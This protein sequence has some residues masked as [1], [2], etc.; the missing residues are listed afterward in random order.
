M[1]KKLIFILGDQL[2]RSL[3]TSE[4]VNKQDDVI[5]MCEV[6]EEATYVKHHKKKLVFVLSSMRHFAQELRDDGYHVDYVKLNDKH[7]S[8]DFT[9]ELKRAVKRHDVE[10]IVCTFPGEYRVYEMMQS[11]QQETGI[12]VDIRQDT[13]FFSQPDDFK[14]WAD[15]R[16]NLRMEYFYR[17]MRKKHHILMEGDA[18]EGGEWNY[19]KENRQPPKKG[20]QPPDPFSADPD[21]ITKD[22]IE[23]V[24]E[25]FSDHF[26]DIEPFYP[27]VNR[28]QALQALDLFIDERLVDF[29]TYQD[30]MIDDEPWMFHAHISPYLNNGLLLANECVERAQQ[31]YRD[32]DAPLHAVEG[33]IRQILGWREYVRGLY[34]LKMPGYADENALNAT[35][36]LPKFFWDG[37]TNMRCVSQAINDTKSY[38]YAHHIKRL[39]IIG[40]FCLLAGIDPKQVNE[41]FLVVYAD[42]YEWV[43]LPNVTGM[44]LYADGGV[45]ASK[46]YAS[47]G[48]Y[49]NKMSDHC[50]HC[51]YAVTKK[52]GDNACPFNYLYWDFLGRNRE[53][54]EHNHRTGM[55]YK[56]LDRMSD[57][58]KDAIREDSR[59]FLETYVPEL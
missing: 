19:D 6:Q 11:W 55:M 58:K 2:S 16:K 48:N 18:P 36:D 1:P 42:A 7:N 56:T 9:S 29:G 46:P 25:H 17:D 31:A 34:W 52:N 45:L 21:D 35:R 5:F 8:G 14:T 30:A 54:L 47:G 12:D 27:A 43:E 38:A 50:K 10:A 33:F 23:M 32:E 4:H 22:V 20:L 40:N 26:G 59:H 57:D 39:M 3:L 53:K 44:A 37:N 51:D 13:R 41:W 28:K 49:I 15:S 24:A